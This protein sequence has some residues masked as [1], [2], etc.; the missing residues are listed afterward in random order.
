MDHLHPPT[1]FLCG[2]RAGGWLWVQLI[3]SRT[4]S[5]DEGVGRSVSF[6][7]I[8]SICIIWSRRTPAEHHRACCFHRYLRNAASTGFD[9]KSCLVIVLGPKYGAIPPMAT[10]GRKSTNERHTCCSLPPRASR[11]GLPRYAGPA[12]TRD[13]QWPPPLS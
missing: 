4:L 5:V 13:D 1:Y 2:S 3:R 11:T 12:S 7:C 9:R 6:S 10:A 8:R